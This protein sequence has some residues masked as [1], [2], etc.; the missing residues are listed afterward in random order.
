MKLDTRRRDFTATR[1]T[2]VHRAARG[3]E[4]EREAACAAL[5]HA[6]LGPLYHFLRREGHGPQEAEELTQ[7]FLLAGFVEGRL[8]AGADR[9]RGR[10]RSYLMRSARHHA[11]DRIRATASRRR[12][13]ATYAARLREEERLVPRFAGT[14]PEA[15]W[16]LRLAMDRLALALRDVERGLRESGDEIRWAVF[17]R[18]WL[19]PIRGNLAGPPHARV[20]AEFELPSPNTV[21][22]WCRDCRRRLRSAFRL[23]V[24]EVLGHDLADG[25]PLDGGLDEWIDGL[26]AE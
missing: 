1:W 15:A 26:L 8:L 13:D 7:S 11:V 5:A 3:S 24:L 23:R 18:A 25:G 16:D 22:D 4:Q 2:L 17:E 12:A 19:H 10:F 20:A 14:S 21:A 9:R 6:Y